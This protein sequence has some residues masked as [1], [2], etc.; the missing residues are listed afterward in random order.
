MAR[1]IFSLAQLVNL[2]LGKVDTAFRHE[3]QRAIADIEDRP[4]NEKPRVVTLKMALK[5]EEVVQGQA[6]TVAAGFQISLDVP[7][8]HT[9]IYSMRVMQNHE[10]LFN[11][12]SPEN[13]NQL[14]LDEEVKRPQAELG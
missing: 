2:D 4:E 8:K 11:A 1:Q 9:R 12:E 3:L 13:P 7:K 6:E 10:L 5:P 14:S